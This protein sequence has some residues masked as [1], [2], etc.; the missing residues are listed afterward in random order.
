[1]DDICRNEELKSQKQIGSQLMAEGFPLM[2][3]MMPPEPAEFQ[4]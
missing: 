1:M 2:I 3:N 4:A